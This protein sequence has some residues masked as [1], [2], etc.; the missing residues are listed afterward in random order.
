M[1]PPTL[2]PL[3]AIQPPS[4]RPLE[5]HPGAQLLISRLIAV[6]TQSLAAATVAPIAV[7]PG[8]ERG[9]SVALRLSIRCGAV[10]DHFGSI[11][12]HLGMS[13]R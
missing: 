7:V 6:L 13:I 10:G 5:N 9:Y 2:R 1:C 3:Y 11:H 8:K 12:R 4:G